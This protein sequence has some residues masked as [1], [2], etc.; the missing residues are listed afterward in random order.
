MQSL[1]EMKYDGSIAKGRGVFWRLIELHLNVL[2]T[3]KNLEQ[4]D[5]LSEKRK[6]I[7]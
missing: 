5:N 3:G 2:L 1:V 6:M 4:H 7:K